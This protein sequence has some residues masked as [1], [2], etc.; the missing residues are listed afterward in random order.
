MTKSI[1]N[2]IQPK[3]GPSGCGDVTPAE[4]DT[5]ISEAV[6]TWQS[7]GLTQ[8]QIA[9]GIATMGVESGF[10]P[11]ARGSSQ[12]EFGL[13]GINDKTWIDAV[14]YYNINSVPDNPEFPKITELWGSARADTQTQLDVIGA[15][16][17]KVWGKAE[18]VQNDSGFQAFNLPYIAYGFWHQGYYSSDNEIGGFLSNPKDFANNNI[19]GYLWNA[20]TTANSILSSQANSTLSGDQSQQIGTLGPAVSSDPIVPVAATNWL[21]ELGK[22]SRGIIDFLKSTA[23]TIKTLQE[24]TVLKEPEVP[25][26]GDIVSTATLKRSSLVTAAER[27]LRPAHPSRST[28]AQYMQSTAQMGVDKNRPLDIEIHIRGD[29]VVF[30]RTNDMNH[31]V[32][33]RLNRGLFAE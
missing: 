29:R 17:K 24:I 15:W 3:Y 1:W 22:Q 6:S 5:I 25:E 27:V 4:K 26:P 14:K 18:N 19:A 31:H 32:S 12:T 16:I 20:Y 21:S 8:N 9:F 2:S 13:G 7:M 11:L 33:V 10:N 28:H 23:K 30:T